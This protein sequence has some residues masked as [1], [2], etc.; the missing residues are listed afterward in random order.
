MIAYVSHAMDILRLIG[1]ILLCES[2]G[3][4]GAIFTAR[5]VKIWYPT[6]VK[7]WFNPPSWVFGPAWTLLYLLM[8]IALYLVWQLP[9]RSPARQAAFALFFLQLA[10][11]AAWSFIFFGM[12]EPFLAFLEISLLWLLIAATIAFFWRVSVPAA[13]L[14]IPYLLWVTFAALLNFAIW[15]LNRAPL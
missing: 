12:R 11:N 1:C 8:G 3:V 9:E 15:R 10:F 2:A 4:V 14:L 13:S 6:L 7:P 5:S